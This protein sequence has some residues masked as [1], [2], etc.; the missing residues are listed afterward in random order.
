MWKTILSLSV[1]AIEFFVQWM[2]SR[3]ERASEGYK[4]FRASY[5]IKKADRLK[6]AAKLAD[7]AKLQQEAASHSKSS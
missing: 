5:E 6:R 3:K 2:E 4:Q 7:D 1:A